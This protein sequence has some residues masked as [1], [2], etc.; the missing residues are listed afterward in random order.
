[1]LKSKNPAKAL[2]RNMSEMAHNI[3]KIVNKWEKGALDNARRI[4]GVTVAKKKKLV[5]ATKPLPRKKQ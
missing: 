4:T 3:E 2:N 5:K 1:M